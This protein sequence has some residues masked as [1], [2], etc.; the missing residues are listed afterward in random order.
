VECEGARG[1]RGARCWARQLGTHGDDVLGEVRLDRL[2]LVHGQAAPA[3]ADEVLQDLQRKE[4]ALEAHGRVDDLVREAPRVGR[5]AQLRQHAVR[6]AAHG[7]GAKVHDLDDLVE[8][9]RL[10]V[11]PVRQVQE[12][13]HLWR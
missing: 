8:Q 11:V 13:L 4:L 5:L 1:A 2:A 12:G 3:V 7:L 9:R 6:L 10:G